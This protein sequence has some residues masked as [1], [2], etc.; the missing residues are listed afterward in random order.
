MKK[1]ILLSFVTF[2]MALPMIHQG[3]VVKAGTV[4]GTPTKPHEDRIIHLTI[5]KIFN[6]IN[7]D[8]SHSIVR[9]PGEQREWNYTRSGI[10]YLPNKVPGYRLE[11]TWLPLSN[12]DNQEINVQYF[13]NPV[14]VTVQ[15]QDKEKNQLKDA[16]VFNKGTIGGHYVIDE[17]QQATIPGF[18]LVTKNQLQ[19]VIQG[20]RNISLIYQKAVDQPLPEE[21]SATKSTELSKQVDS[22]GSQN[23]ATAKSGSA[24]T[25]PEST[26][27]SHTKQTGT[28]DKA[29][30]NHSNESSSKISKEQPTTSPTSASPKK[31]AENQSQ[32]VNGTETKSSSTNPRPEVP[33]N[34]A[35]VEIPEKSGTVPNQP[36]KKSE[37][38]EVKTLPQKTAEKEPVKEDSDKAVIQRNQVQSLT[39]KPN[40]KQSPLSAYKQT[41]HLV[42]VDNKAHQLFTKTATVNNDELQNLINDNIEFYGYNWQHTDYNEPTNT[43]TLHYVPKKIAVKVINVDETGKEISSREVTADFGTDLTI[44][45]TTIN[46]YAALD[47][48]K[49]IQVNN[50]LPEAIQFHY[51]KDTPDGA[52]D[53]Q[54]VAATVEKDAAGHDS[55]KRHDSTPAPKETDG[56]RHSLADKEDQAKLPQT[57]ESSSSKGVV[58]GWLML[59]ALAG[60]KILK[61]SR[62]L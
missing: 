33:T 43:F 49:K 17:R 19:G 41:V 27:D 39:P 46:G 29:T 61:R 30:S 36:T 50:V 31:P 24:D 16:I 15:F 45:P 34:K 26:A 20:N 56:K 4:A 32:I 55:S 37:S 14:E 10:S 9:Q 44:S 48:E 38:T 23:A 51:R 52:A 53:D 57:G 62:Q 21:T 5:N 7:T 11:K 8:G 3:V 18:D 47:P 59:I 6:S 12:S 1:W 58:M 35:K 42:G 2:G 25:N 13:G 60:Q 40:Q 54:S 28:F 22:K